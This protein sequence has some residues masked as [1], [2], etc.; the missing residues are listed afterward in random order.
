MTEKPHIKD[1]GHSKI[2]HRCNHW[3]TRFSFL[4]LFFMRLPPVVLYGWSLTILSLSYFLNRIILTLE[5]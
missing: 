3:W 2:H 1:I 4:V 5:G